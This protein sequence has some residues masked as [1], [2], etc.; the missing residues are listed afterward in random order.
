VGR[1]NLIKGPDL[2]LEAFFKITKDYSNYLLVFAGNDDGLEPE[3][4]GLV[5]QYGLEKKVKFIGF[6][7]DKLKSGLYHAADLLVIPSRFEAM[8]I[9][10]LESAVTGTPVLMTNT[11]GLNE[12]TGEHG[13]HSVSPDIAS[14]EEGLRTLLSESEELVL[15]GKNMKLYV[16]NSFAWGSVIKKYIKMYENIIL[17]SSK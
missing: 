4:K 5:K 9:V 16:E 14:L 3:L 2:L 13:A 17:F 10:V 1:L 11:C 7:H 15:R 8:S 6:V 12:M